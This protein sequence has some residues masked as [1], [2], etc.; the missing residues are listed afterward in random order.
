VEEQGTTDKNSRLEEKK[1]R[2][3]AYISSEG[4]KNVQKGRTRANEYKHT[5]SLIRSYSQRVYDVN[6]GILRFIGDMGD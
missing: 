3:P 5:D 6:A 2:S 4:N 1:G